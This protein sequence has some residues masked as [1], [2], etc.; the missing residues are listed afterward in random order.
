MNIASIFFK[1]S[2]LT[3]HY[4]RNFEK[5]PDITVLKDI[6]YDDRYG[7]YTRAD[8]YYKDGQDSYPVIINVHGGGFVKGDKRHRAAVCAKFARQGYFVYNIN[9][10]LAPQYQF[11][12]ACEDVINAINFLPKLQ[13][14]FKLSL[15]NIILTGD[16]AGAYY[17]M[18]AILASTNEEFRQGLS[19]PN[20]NEKITGFMG[21]CGAYSLEVIVAR[22]TPLN[23]AKEVGS[24]VI[25]FKVK[26]DFSNLKDFPLFSYTNLLDF[27]NEKF[28][29]SYI[30]ASK[31][32]KFVGGQGELLQEKLESLGVKHSVHFADEV[33]DFHCF[34]LLP[35]H[36]NTKKVMESAYKW[37]KEQQKE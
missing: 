5:F 34:Q 37:L 36:K 6:S 29:P 20:C 7:R 22:K 33:G 27:I 31:H 19:L 13:K 25:G 35:K 1:I 21:F 2:D 9:Y 12:A 4:A 24:A 11:P 15:D 10:R 3:M 28:P 8:V 30:M 32:D 14:Q 26:K 23:V 16:S 17:A 18:T